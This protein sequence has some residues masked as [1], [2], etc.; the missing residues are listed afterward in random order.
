MKKRIIFILSLCFILSCVLFSACQKDNKTNYKIELNYYEYQLQ[1]NYSFKLEYSGCPYAQFSSSNDQIATVDQ[2]GIVIGKS[3][4]KVEIRVQCENQSKTCTVTVVSV[5]QFTQVLSLNVDENVNVLKSDN[6]LRIL[7][8]LLIDGKETQTE[9]LFSSQKESVATI[10]KNG[11]IK[12]IEYGITAITVSANYKGSTLSKTVILSVI[13]DIDIRFDNYSYTLYTTSVN[14]KQNTSFSPLF[15]GVYVDG[16]KDE[17]ATVSYEYDQNLLKFENGK[18]SVITSDSAKT[19]F[20]AVYQDENGIKY[21]CPISV[22]ILF[23][24]IDKTNQTNYY[25]GNWKD[26]LRGDKKIGREQITF[27]EKVFEEEIVDI[28]DITTGQEKDLNYNPQTCELENTELVK[29]SKTW[30]IYNDKY[31]VT[32]SVTVVDMVI[33]TAEEFVKTLSIATDEHIVIGKDI[34]NVGQYQNT[35]NIFTGIL[36]GNYHT[37]SGIDFSKATAYGGLF[38]RIDNATIK[39]IAFD[40]VDLSVYRHTEDEQTVAYPHGLIGYQGYR[41]TISNVFA[42]IYS[43]ASEYEGGL[44]HWIGAGIIIKDT[45]IVYQNKWAGSEVGVL[46]RT[47]DAVVTIDNVYIIKNSNIALI[48]SFAQSL[49]AENKLQL[50]Q[51]LQKANVDFEDVE[52]FYLYR[53]TLNLTKFHMAVLEKN[54]NGD[55]YENDDFTD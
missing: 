5:E 7:P 45:V 3:A 49:T 17:D 47:S 39:N 38:Y 1:V 19:Q 10:D 54:G 23:P 43:T 14:Y 15:L 32:V 4:G 22:E 20:T 31:A 21:T 36:D 37:V 27:T 55:N 46:S 24:V 28:Y 29:G 34:D 25:V 53:N 8:K 18:V 2:S 9:F 26:S 51:N 13:A 30:K 40:K 44:F 52:Q 50:E 6:T 12:P 42:Q 16:V 11:L 48:K 33:N 35:S 41:S